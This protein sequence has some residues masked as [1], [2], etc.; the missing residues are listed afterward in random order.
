M[1]S[2]N[3]KI[4]YKKTLDYDNDTLST[5]SNNSKINLDDSIISIASNKNSSSDYNFNMQ[6]I[7]EDN[8]NLIKNIIEEINIDLKK[9]SNDINK[10]NLN[11]YNNLENFDN[12]N[13]INNI[14]HFEIS[15]KNINVDTL[16]SESNYTIIE[17]LANNDINSWLFLGMIIISIVII[18]MI[19]LNNN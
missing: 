12:I 16:K 4:I 18:I 9:K 2:I 10:E 14:E 11:D 3:N 8:L 13:N 6:K 7:N 1:N 5:Y 17:R 19:I 15:N